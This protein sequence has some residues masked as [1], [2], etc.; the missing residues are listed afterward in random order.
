MATQDNRLLSGILEQADRTARAKIEEAQKRATEI[1]SE[2]AVRCEA[3][4]AAQE[5]ELAQRLK[6]VELRLETNKASSR[7]KALL[8]GVDQRYQRVMDRVVELMDPATITPHFPLWIA[9]AVVGL[10]LSEAKVAFS[11]KAPVTEEHLRS[12]EALVK[13][14]IGV[15][16]TLHLDP[17]PIRGLGIV[18]SSLDEGVSFN[19]QVEI[20]LRRFDRDIRALIQEHA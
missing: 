15:D 3:Q 4:V 18:V 20:R 5:R 6:Q 1:L 7:R 17:K 2:A 12:A 10:D 14:A 19:N 8:R 11:R 9:E 13:Q 16:V